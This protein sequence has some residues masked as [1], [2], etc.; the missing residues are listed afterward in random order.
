M[1]S[2]DGFDRFRFT[3]SDFKVSVDGRGYSCDGMGWGKREDGI[4]GGCRFGGLFDK[5]RGRL[6]SLR[7]RQE[8]LVVNFAKRG[9]RCDN[10]K[11]LTWRCLRDGFRVASF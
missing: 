9:Q 3:F 5:F 6:D 2:E 4:Q 7:S 1:R 11:R 10:R 8:S